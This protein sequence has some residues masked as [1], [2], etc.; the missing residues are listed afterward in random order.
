MSRSCRVVKRFC[1]RSSGRRA[2]KKPCQKTVNGATVSGTWVNTHTRPK[3]CV[4]EPLTRLQA[5]VRSRSQWKKYQTQR[6][7]ATRLQA[8]AK[9]RSQ[10]RR[11]V[12]QVDAI[13]RIQRA[14]RAMK[15]GPS[16][17]GDYGDAPFHVD[18]P[19]QAPLPPRKSQRVSK[20]NPRPRLIE[21]IGLPHAPANIPVRPAR[22]SKGQ[23]RPRLIEEMRRRR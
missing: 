22:T 23:P 13:R 7:S 9:K 18:P 20:G 15:R 19:K 10:Q 17:Y 12:Q 6:D 3:A 5:A 21:E 4:P 1:R 8:T 14:S 2:A 16:D 11:Y